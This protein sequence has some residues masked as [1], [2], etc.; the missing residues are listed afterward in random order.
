M[1]IWTAQNR[2]QRDRVPAFTLVELLVV[3]SIITLIASMTLFTL[4]GVPRE[5]ARE[6]RAR[7]QVAR[8]HELIM[9]QWEGYRTRAVPVLTSTSGMDPRSASYRRLYALRQLLRMELPDRKTDLMA[10]ATELKSPPSLWRDTFAEPRAAG[11]RNMRTP[12]VCI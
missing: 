6:R 8:I 7:S 2:L 10:G 4:Q 11:L 9:Q 1:N 12:S 3:I 5:D